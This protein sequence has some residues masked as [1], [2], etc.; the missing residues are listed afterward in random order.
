M[1]P[2][3][4]IVLY[5]DIPSGECLILIYVLL[6]WILSSNIF[7]EELCYYSPWLFCMFKHVFHS[8]SIIWLHRKLA[9]YPFFPWNLI[10]IFCCCLVLRVALRER[11]LRICALWTKQAG[12]LPLNFSLF[13]VHLL[14]MPI[15]LIFPGI[16]CVLSI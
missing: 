12:Q 4:T 1:D 3:L 6:W 13:T 8:H 11:D 2:I 5:G 10:I 7:Q 15:L 16:W 14:M 9:G